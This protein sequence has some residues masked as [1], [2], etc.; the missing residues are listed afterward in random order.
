[1]PTGVST[2]PASPF[3]VAAGQSVAVLF[4]AASNAQTGQYNLTAQGTSGTLS[5]AQ[6]VALAIQAAPPTNLPRTRFVEDDLVTAVD[7]PRDRRRVTISSTTPPIK[8]FYVANL[9]MNR[10]RF[11]LP[12]HPRC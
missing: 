11:F 7:M 8:R 10:V 5:H 1:L 2:N 3:S 9:A 4:G 12:R 6:T